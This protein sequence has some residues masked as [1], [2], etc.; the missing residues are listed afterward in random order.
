MS[1]LFYYYY[2]YPYYLV[3]VTYLPSSSYSWYSSVNLVQVV[4]AMLSE[5]KQHKSDQQ[6][7]LNASRPQLRFTKMK[8]NTKML[9]REEKS[10]AGQLS[11]RAGVL[12]LCSA[13]ASRFSEVKSVDTA[14][15]LL[16][17]AAARTG[18]ISSHLFLLLY[19]KPKYPLI[20]H[21]PLAANTGSTH[22]MPNLFSKFNISVLTS[23]FQ[24]LIFFLFSC[25]LFLWLVFFV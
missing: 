19:R 16:L 4:A 11:A 23:K 6:S 15:L 8:V 21:W 1:L 2:Y 7:N 24:I 3:L 17:L 9:T 10:P 18:M 25:L 14:P 5:I 20:Q 13:G 12:W 22:E